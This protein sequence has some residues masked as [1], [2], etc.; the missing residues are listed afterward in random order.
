MTG[1]PRIAE[2]VLEEIRVY[3]LSV[4]G[5]ERIIREER[6][7]NSIKELEKDP[8][9][10]KTILKLEHFPLV[11]QNVDKGKGIVFDF[12]DQER[13][14][15]VERG[16]QKDQKLLASAIQSSLVMSRLPRLDGTL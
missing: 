3:L 9:G 10:Q 16:Q 1:R 7:K 5:P 8:M 2:E 15:H 14:R 6:V 4:N 13:I 12:E 11:S